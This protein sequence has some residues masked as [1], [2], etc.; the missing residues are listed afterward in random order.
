MGS[1]K[2]DIIYNLIAIKKG[3]IYEEGKY[4]TLVPLV[5][6]CLCVVGGCGTPKGTGYKG[7]K[8]YGEKIEDGKIMARI[9]NDFRTN[10][11]ISDDLSIYR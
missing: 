1:D 2:G 3:V 6:L 5:A 11:A 10:P 7:C 4:L 8:T 9:R